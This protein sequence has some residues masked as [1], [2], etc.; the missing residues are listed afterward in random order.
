MSDTGAAPP[1]SYVDPSLLP[2]VVPHA[3]EPPRIGPGAVFAREEREAAEDAWLAP[4]ATRSVGAGSRAAPEELDPW[5]T[6]FER[7]LDRVTHAAA[8]R[9]LAGKTQVFIHPDDMART[10][11]THALEVAQIGVA[12]ARA[13][14]LNV[15][16]VEAAARAH[17]CGHGPFGHK[18]ESALSPFVEGGFDHAPWGAEVTLAEHNLTAEVL[19]AVANHSW[20]RPMPA[21]PEGLCVSL[22]DRLAYV[23]HDVEDALR[24]G[25]VVPSDFPVEIAAVLSGRK[26][27]LIADLVGAAVRSVCSTGVVGLEQYAGEV[28]QSVRDF[29]YAVIYDRPES[30]AQGAAVQQ[31]IPALVRRLAEDDT[32][33]TEVPGGGDDATA[34]RCAVAYV[35]GC[36]DRHAIRTARRLGVE[37][38]EVLLETAL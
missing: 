21:T 4:G 38:P 11:L 31:F 32:G 23:A 28:L 27:D 8:F 2:A 7:D 5:R 9:R 13:A 6:C 35:A 14:R 24:A 1:T 29:A 17:D 30:V 34:L 10:R 20:K 19:D 22:A 12:I 33:I 37:V 26:R 15:A 18:C 3:G 25:V 16:L 36:T